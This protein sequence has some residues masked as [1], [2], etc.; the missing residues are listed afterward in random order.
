MSLA[1]CT[2]QAEQTQAQDQATSPTTVPSLAFPVLSAVIAIGIFILDT[3]TPAEVAIAVLYVGVVL[4]TAKVLQAR[5]VALAAVGCMTLT[6]LSYVLAQ[7]DASPSIAL[8]NRL[9]SLAAIGVTAFLAVQSRSREMV[10]REQAGLLDLT[11]DTIFVRDMNDVI[12]YWNRGAEELYGWSTGEAVGQVSH[13]L[14]QTIFPMPLGEITAELLRTGRWEGELVHTRKDGT[15]AIVASRWSI[16]RDA[17]GRPV[18]ILETNNDITE[19]KRAEE[20][21]R[22]SE[23]YLAEAEALSKSGIW[24]WNPITKRIA[25]WSQERSR[26]FGFDPEAGIPSFEALLQRIHPE[27]RGKWLENSER[28]VRIRGDSETDFRIVLPDGEIKHLHGVGHPVFSESGNLVEII[29]AAMDITE[30]KRAEEALRESEEQW[31]AVFENNPTMYFIVDAAGTILSVNPLGAEQLGYTPAELVG[32]PVLNVFYEPDREAVQR[33]VARCF[34]QLNWAM[35]WEARK[36]RKDGTVLWVRETAR[37]VLLK[38]CP[39]ILVACED[40]TE[41]KH[42]E[43]AA[44]RSEQELRDLIEH[45]PAMVYIALPGPSGPVVAFASRG[46]RDYSGLS[47]EDTAGSGWQSVVHPADLDRNLEKWRVRAAAGE[48]YENESR[49]RRAADGACRWFL[50]RAVP[51]RD[52]HGTILKWYGV[53]TD[54]ED[55]KRAEDA[56]RRSEHYL[57]EAQRL[58]HTG[59][60]VY[61]PATEQVIYWSEEMFRIH[62]LDPQRDPAPDL[63]ELTRFWHPDDCGRVL[64]RVRTAF[65]EKA[66]Y[67]VEHRI[68]LP[69]GTIKRLHAI[70]H[71][72]F[73]DTGAVIEYIGTVM[74][75]TEHRRA[76]EA[77]H[78]AQAELA[79]V[80]RVTTMSALT[81]SIAHEVNQPLGAIVTNASAALRWLAHE[82]PNLGEACEILERIARD[83]HRAS[84]VIGRVR[85]LLQ[86]KAAVAEQVNLDDLIQNVAALAHGEV[87]QHRILLRT[88]LAP[89]LLPVMGDQVQLQQVLL[90]LVL[91]GIEAMMDV[92]ERPRELVI[93][94]RRE[95]AG[96]LVAVQDAGVGLDPQNAERMFEAFYTTKPAGMGMGLAICRS[97]IEAHG[98]RLWASANEPQGAVFHFS[99]P[100]D[101]AGRL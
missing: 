15:Q 65:R 6:I 85:S 64:E 46:W 80:T 23:A 19:R 99:L 31:K 41:R 27:D 4:L 24:A 42:A 38:N 78:K 58:S 48:P 62:G 76:E 1:R 74:D 33:H 40:I 60:C 84:E 44:R 93:R 54:I 35:S 43:E 34:D 89:N 39:V 91:N 11:H 77:L 50:D 56:L 45:L 63:N 26:L 83:G 100:V 70:G 71:P 20:E 67:A 53:L 32:S 28:A 22:R 87:V 98:G 96:V 18:A 29:G 101:R 51:L 5:G 47:Q 55:R 94:S 10:L 61:N 30:R 36:M 25:Y 21:L 9:L 68:V 2:M 37:A 75:M 72:V 13:H 57:A 59:S 14:M 81:A 88:E 66:E 97:I 17:R 86:K 95:K 92:A 49:Y 16:Q 69:D 79:H 73:D 7:H 8:L 12:I 90:N 3:M 82:P 52:E